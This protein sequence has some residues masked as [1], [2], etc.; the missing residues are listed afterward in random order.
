M[1][2]V[3]IADDHAMLRAGL[4]ATL[5]ALPD[6]ELAPDISSGKDFLA[7]VQQSQADILICDVAM[8]EFQIV[9]A[10]ETLRTQGPKPRVLVFS[11]EANRDL[12]H[13]VTNAGAV[14][15]VLKDELESGADLAILLNTVAAGRTWFS[16]GVQSYFAPASAQDT[17]T[18]RERSVLALMRQG[19]GAGDIARHLHISVSYVYSLQVL[20]RQKYQVT[21]NTALLLKLK[22]S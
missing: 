10:L 13:A 20:M 2:R 5:S 7:Q 11:G 4:R 9:A 12:V 3:Q 6:I 18:S 16:P 21:T 15:Y 22:N 19:Q 14:G 17:L 8:P 1:L